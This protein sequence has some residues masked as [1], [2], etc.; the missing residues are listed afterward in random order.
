MITRRVEFGDHGSAAALQG[1]AAACGAPLRVVVELARRNELRALF[2]GG[3]T[4]H[5]RSA[6]AP[7]LSPRQALLK[8]RRKRAEWYAPQ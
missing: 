6:D 7:P 5:H 2:K 3:K 8:L 4:F 1:L